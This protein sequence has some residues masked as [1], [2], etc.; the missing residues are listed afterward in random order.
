MG[1]QSVQ[2]LPHQR[3]KR[4]K[5]KPKHLALC[6]HALQHLAQHKGF[7]RSGGRTHRHGGDGLRNK[8]A[9]MLAINVA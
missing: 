6:A 2:R 8:A 5:P 9:L 7:A 3:H 4:H 1:Q